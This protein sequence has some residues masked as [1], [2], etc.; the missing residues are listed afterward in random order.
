MPR[1]AKE[2]AD[3]WR[4]VDISTPDACWAWQGATNN[5]GYGTTGWR[6]RSQGAHA[7]AWEL[8]HGAV[9]Q[10]MVVCHTCDC[11]SCC[12]PSHLQLGSH[13]ENMADM[14]QNGRASKSTGERNP[15]AK[16]DDGKVREIRRLHASGVAKAEIARRF[17]VGWKTVADIVARRTWRHI[18]DQWF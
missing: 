17:G 7:V 16:L 18:G 3:F 14:I 2:A 9:P 8:T 1:R 11:P 4:K 12:N 15:A 5:K 6:G 13:A 10:G